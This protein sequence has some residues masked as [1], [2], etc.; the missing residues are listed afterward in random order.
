MSSW[1]GGGGDGGGKKP[2]MSKMRCHYEV[3]GLERS[4]TEAE[5]KKAYKKQALKWHPDRNFGNE[6]EQRSALKR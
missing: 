1:F 6:A 4:A 5:V 3:M 2:P